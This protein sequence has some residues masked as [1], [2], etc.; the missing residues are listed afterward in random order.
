MNPCRITVTK[1]DDHDRV[2]IERRNVEG[3]AISSS[4]RVDADLYAILHA[5]EHELR[6]AFRPPDDAITRW[7]L[8]DDQ[9]EPVNRGFG[10]D[11]T[12]EGAS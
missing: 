7:A 8:G 4:Y 12:T 6:E 2:L 11:P 1:T 10:S 5:V 3:T 9:P